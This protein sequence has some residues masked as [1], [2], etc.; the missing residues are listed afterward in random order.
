MARFEAK[1]QGLTNRDGVDY[2]DFKPLLESLPGS[3]DKPLCLKLFQLIKKYLGRYEEAPR[4]IVCLN[5]ERKAIAPKKR[6]AMLTRLSKELKKWTPTE[7]QKPAE[8][9][10]RL[11]K[12]FEGYKHRYRKFFEIFEAEGLAPRKIVEFNRDGALLAKFFFVKDP[13]GYEIEVLQR[14][15]RYR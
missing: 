10:Q 12:I 4:Y 3:E 7:E 2:A 14:H 5:E 1:I 13:D 6:A 9:E 11:D 15:G 8:I